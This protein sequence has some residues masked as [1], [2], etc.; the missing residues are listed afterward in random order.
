MH[1]QT[2]LHS[3]HSAHRTAL[4]E[5]PVEPGEPSAVK[6]DSTLGCYCCAML[7]RGYL[8]PMS[9][10][11]SSSQRSV[12]HSCNITHVCSVQS[13]YSVS[14]SSICLH[15]ELDIKELMT[16]ADLRRRKC[17]CGGCCSYTRV[18]RWGEEGLQPEA[19]NAQ[20]II[21]VPNQ[22]SAAD[23]SIHVPHTHHIVTPATEKKATH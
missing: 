14:E 1:W 19:R 11:A 13:V 5:S 18:W 15:D 9:R 10:K 3:A 23:Q 22:G 2:G 21:L 8:C 4:K 6:L 16:A 7:D 17:W 12:H 20:D